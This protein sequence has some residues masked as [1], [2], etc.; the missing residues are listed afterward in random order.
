M[1]SDNDKWHDE[2]MYNASA[3]LVMGSNLSGRIGP[4][5]IY[6]GSPIIEKDVA[7]SY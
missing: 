6:S 3:P 1:C 7:Y 4:Q 2:N 5:I